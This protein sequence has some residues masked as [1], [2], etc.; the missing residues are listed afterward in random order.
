MAR[1]KWREMRRVEETMGGEE[2]CEG[3]SSLRRRTAD[4][5][6]TAQDKKPQ[7]SSTRCSIYGAKGATHLLNQGPQAAAF[8]AGGGEISLR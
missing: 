3:C 6:A 5:R 8:R 4:E 7:F 2:T 1:E